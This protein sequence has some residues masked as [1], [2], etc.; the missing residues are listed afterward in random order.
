MVILARSVELVAK[1]PIRLLFALAF[2]G[3]TVNLLG[4]IFVSCFVLSSFSRMTETLETQEDAGNIITHEVS[5]VICIQG[6]L[7]ERGL[8]VST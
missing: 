2:V 4:I 8:D 3:S 6:P 5:E 7:S 1:M